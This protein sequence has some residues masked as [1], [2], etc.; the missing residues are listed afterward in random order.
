MKSSRILVTTAALA[1]VSLVTG[2]AFGELVT[3]RVSPKV[4]LTQTLGVTDITLV[5]SRPGVRNRTVWGELVPM[6]KPWRTGANEATTFTTSHDI[7]INGQSLPAGTYSFFTIPDATEWTIVFSKQK[8]LWGAFDYDEKQDQLRVKAQP[9]AAEYREWME[10]DFEELSPAALPQ[11]PSAG[12]LVLRWEK[13]AV[14]ITVETDMSNLV[15]ASARDEMSKLKADDWRTP[16]RAASFS[17]DN[18]LNNQAEAKGWAQKSVSIQENFQ[19]LSL[20]AKI[21]AKEGKKK[22]AVATA[23]KAV[24]LG[25]ASKNPVDTAPTEKLIA[26]WSGKK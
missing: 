3:P 19:N 15:L 18:N 22:D 24:K 20:L 10:L 8:D 4:S 21:Q 14:P 25:K 16:F 12:K 9:V 5:Y 26:E 1:A 17:F 2:V 13:I 6:G 23:N 11:S 7:K